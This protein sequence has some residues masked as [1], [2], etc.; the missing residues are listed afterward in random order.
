LIIA[1]PVAPKYIVERL[2]SEVDQIEIM[3]K[4]SDFKAVDQF[5]Q[6][7]EAVSDD[8]IVQIA[9]RRLLNY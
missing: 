2:K 9:K 4:P 8:Q 6:E 7:F 1:A 3:R 5:Y